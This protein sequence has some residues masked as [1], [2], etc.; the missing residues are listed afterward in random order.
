M[1]RIASERRRQLGD[2]C[3]G[4]GHNSTELET[5]EKEADTAAQSW[6]M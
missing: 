3:K 6:E 1:F 5:N 4:F 2:K